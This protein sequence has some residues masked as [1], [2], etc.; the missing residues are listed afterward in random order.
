M[1][2]KAMLT[3]VHLKMM[4]SL[5]NMMDFAFKMM[6]FAFKMMNL[7]AQDEI[8]QLKQALKAAAGV[9]QMMILY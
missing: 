2:Q 9:L 5:L 6:D 4:N 3:E 1:D 7:Q 8:E